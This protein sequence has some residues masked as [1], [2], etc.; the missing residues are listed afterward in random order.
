MNCTITCV[1]I[2]DHVLKWCWTTQAISGFFQAAGFLAAGESGFSMVDPTSADFD[3]TFRPDSIWHNAWAFLELCVS[4]KGQA[5]R[6]K[7]LASALWMR[8]I[9]MA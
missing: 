2:A 5:V 6:H 7:I 1:H 9:K 3:K 4:G 8:W